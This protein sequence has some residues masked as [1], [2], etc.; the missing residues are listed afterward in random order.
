[1]NEDNNQ[2]T[3]LPISVR[4]GLVL[5]PAV[6]GEQTLQRFDSNNGNSFT[7]N[8][9]STEIR[10]NVSGS[11]FLLGSEAYLSFDIQ[12]TVAAGGADKNALL[13]NSAADIIE[14][15]RIESNGVEI[16]RIDGYNLI[17][18]IKRDYKTFEDT[19]MVGSFEGAQNTTDAAAN[20]TL[21]FIPKNS[22]KSYVLRLS[23]GFLSGGKLAK[24]IPL[25][26]TSGFTLIIRL[27]K[28]DDAFIAVKT[29]LTAATSKFSQYL[30]K[31]N[32]P[33]LYAPV[34]QIQDAGFAARYS[35]MMGSMGIEWTAITS[36][37]YSNTTS[38]G[39]GPHALQLNDRS[40]SLRGFVSVLRSNAMSA[41]AYKLNTLAGDVTKIDTFRYYISGVE[42]PLGGIEIKASP[43]KTETGRAFLE[44]LKLFSDMTDPKT[45]VDAAKFRADTTAVTARSKGTM[46][47]DLK[48]YGDG[49]L[50]L[51]GMPTAASTTPSVLEFKSNTDQFDATRV[52][53]FALC[54]VIY[55]LDQ[56]GGFSS[57]Y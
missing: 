50:S 19:K 26:N 49:N 15:L 18:A 46:S 32:N 47:V 51:T 22:S 56:N 45:I 37:R 36:K 53:T 24:A 3:A 27:A 5:P 16:E 4:Y 7:M 28:P 54:D 25:L 31:I 41:D 6:Q 13:C 20:T 29:D 52:D 43:T 39:M 14:S 11:G 23:S 44:T 2:S 10:I 40:V 17:D 34:F 21:A 33:R 48:R 38:T 42:T 1:M 9:A 55:R 57:V 35:Q 12:N 30:P 8:G